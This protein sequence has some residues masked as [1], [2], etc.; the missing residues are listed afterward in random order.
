MSD[1]Q[2]K[3]VMETIVSESAPVLHSYTDRSGLSFAL[4]TNMATA[5]G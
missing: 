3:R 1:E 5:K 4:S 2:R